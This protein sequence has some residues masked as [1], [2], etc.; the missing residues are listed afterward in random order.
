[1]GMTVTYRVAGD[2]NR[3]GNLSV[4]IQKEQPFF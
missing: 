4:Y 2:H 1:M 3:D